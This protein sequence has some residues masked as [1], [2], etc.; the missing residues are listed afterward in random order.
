MD[1]PK[2]NK[3]FA[4][5]IIGVL[6]FIFGFVTWLN[7]VL[8]PFLKI[9]CELDMQQAF[10]VAS[11]FYIAYFVM[12]IPVSFIIRKAGFVNSMSLGLM[13]MLLGTLMF[14]PAAYLREYWVFL[15][16]LFIQGTGLTLLQTAS[17]PYVTLLGPVESAAR[18]ISIMGIANKVAG[19]MSG[20]ILGSILLT[21]NDNEIADDLL[22][23]ESNP[24]I[25]QL[26]ARKLY[27]DDLALKVVG[28]YLVMAAVLLL[29]ALMIRMTKL[30]ETISDSENQRFRLKGIPAYSY[31]G[32]L[33]IFFYVGAEVIVGDSIISYGRDLNPDPYFISL[34]GQE[35]NVLNPS[36]FTSYVMT[37]MILGY[38]IGIILIPR[39][40]NQAN[41][42]R[43]FSISAIAFSLLALTSH[44]MMSLFF[45]IL[46]GISNSIMWPAIWPLAIRNT[47]QQTPVVSAMLIMGIIGGAVLSPSF[48]FLAEI[49]G[50]HQ[51]YWILLPCYL[52]ILYYASF[53]HRTGEAVI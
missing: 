38:F 24:L 48:G 11:A 29:L 39:L 35:I 9:A 25:D 3:T 1:S 40:M 21:K 7:G 27:F 10:Y 34:L 2:T 22:A 31:L 28:P 19:A 30:P 37:G 41:A 4:L 46:L 14:I 49:V 8:I 33:A 45:I 32:F 20:V 16:G 50:M 51:A 43:W 5:V 44:G 13:I 18:R 12:A 6:F 36:Y 15:A 52:Y 26:L 23:I 17:N 42:L 53:G 47:G